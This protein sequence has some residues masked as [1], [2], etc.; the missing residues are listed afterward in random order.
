MSVRPA[1]SGMSETTTA[2]TERPA[3]PG[4]YPAPPPTVGS[5][6]VIIHDRSRTVLG[7]LR[8]SWS[9]R[10]AAG[11][12]F[13]SEVV[14]FYANTRLGRFWVL[15]RPAF[16]ALGKTLIFGGVLGA[17]SSNGTP[18]FLF[19]LTG[20]GLFML[21]E[22][23][24]RK[25]I[26]AMQSATKWAR[27]MNFPLVLAVPAASFQGIIECALYGVIFVIGVLF[28]WVVKGHLYLVI[29]PQLLL[30]P[31]A[32]VVM[33]TLCMGLTC[34]LS[35]FNW[36]A[37]DVRYILR[38]VMGFTMLVTP[39][40]YPLDSLHGTLRTIALLNPLAAPVEMYK[41]ALIGAG[42][43]SLP[44]TIYSVVFAAVA[45]VTGIWYVNHST[46]KL[47]AMDAQK[48]T[49]DDDDDDM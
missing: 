15:F 5:S 20:M 42:R 31:V 22:R 35:V 47:L 39:V 16:D 43:I 11:W 30:A 44:S 34:W 9:A 13:L 14:S 17:A 40:V 19:V 8:E 41:Y 23:G 7:T 4:S 25:G 37:A 10:H 36:H 2:T 45:F 1:S 21:F 46:P 3:A 27:N 49:D 48:T 29:A 24:L 28:Y 18:Y 32:L 33:F 6:P 12:L 38:S 26:K